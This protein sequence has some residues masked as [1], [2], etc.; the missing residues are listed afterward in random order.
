MNFI[1]KLFSKEKAITVKN[2]GLG[3]F[4]IPYPTSELLFISNEDVN[5]IQSPFQVTISIGLGGVEETKKGDFYSEPSLIWTKLP[6]Q[7]NNE[8]EEQKMYYPAYFSLSPKCRYQYLQWLKDISRET[9]LSYVFLYYYGL[10]RHLLLGNY[11]LAAEEIVK[12]I[13]YHDKGTFKGYATSALIASSIYRKNFDIFKRYA[14]ILNQLSNP[15]IFIRAQIKSD[16]EPK[17]VI[18]LSYYVG[19]KNK[20]YI[21]EKRGLFID[22]LDGQIEKFRSENGLIL[23]NIDW[24]SMEYDE[25][26]FFANISIP[27]SIRMIKTPNILQNAKFKSI[28]F[29]LL[30]DTHNL[31]KGKIKE[32][33]YNLVAKT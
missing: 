30:A 32:G 16:L 10:E 24:E 22:I 3:D 18:E 33:E 28:L 2:D 15:C 9:N 4:G 29:N 17:E 14:S 26:I 1:K 27:G 20:R 23:D 25:E 7:K 21:K 12:L 31:V 13:K 5:K 19:F 6:I 11:D 8:L